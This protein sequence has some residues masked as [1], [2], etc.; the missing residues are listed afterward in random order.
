VASVVCTLPGLQGFD[1]L[2]LDAAGHVCVAT[3]L[4]G[5][6]ASI[7]PDGATVTQYLLPQGL[8]DHMTTNLCFGGPGLTTAY[9][10]LGATGRLVSCPWPAP[11]LDL[12]FNC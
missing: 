2:A 12:A 10:T 6:I 11:G 4:T 8:E 5:G 9:I 3:L 7:A 1:S